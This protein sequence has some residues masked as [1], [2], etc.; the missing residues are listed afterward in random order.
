MKTWN[1]LV[2]KKRGNIPGM[3]GCK[4]IMHPNISKERI[5]LATCPIRGMIGITVLHRGHEAFDKRVDNFL[6][7][8]K[9]KRLK[10]FNFKL[11]V[12]T[13]FEL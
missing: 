3:Q 12:S 8:H 10:N 13:V 11:Q 4:E 9:F 2:L 1:I 6:H 7:H 5:F